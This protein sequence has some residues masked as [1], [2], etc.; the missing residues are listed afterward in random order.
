MPTFDEVLEMINKLHTDK[1]T[2]Y[3]AQT[4]EFY[5]FHTAEPVNIGLLTPL[6]Y[7]LTLPAKHDTAMWLL[8]KDRIINRLSGYFESPEEV[9]SSPYFR[10]GGD[11]KL[12]EC[13]MDGIVYRIIAICLL[14]EEI[15]KE[16]K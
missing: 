10:R 13:L 5:N 2:H 11:A 6:E 4:D 12:K 8:L 15:Q 14:E 3:G 1:T 16:P 9:V 7:C